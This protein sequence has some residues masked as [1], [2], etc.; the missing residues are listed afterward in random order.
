MGKL[1][2]WIIFLLLLLVFIC[3]GFLFFTKKKM[4]CL[5][6]AL[7][8]VGGSEYDISLFG[9][10]KFHAFDAKKYGKVQGMGVKIIFLIIKK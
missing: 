1:I 2:A 10:E 3:V 7:P 6:V 5:G 4:E 8:V 9:L